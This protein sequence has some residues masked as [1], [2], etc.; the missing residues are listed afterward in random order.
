MACCCS[1]PYSARRYPY[2]EDDHLEEETY[3]FE[4][5]ASIAADPFWFQTILGGL[6]STKHL[7]VDGCLVERG[8][9]FARKVLLTVVG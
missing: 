4:H 2:P 1:S 8:S 3:Q 5:L 6:P 7:G 9:S